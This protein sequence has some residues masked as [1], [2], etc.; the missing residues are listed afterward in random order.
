[1]DSNKYVN[2]KSIIW[3]Y[4]ELWFI[5]KRLISVRMYNEIPPSNDRHISTYHSIR[6]SAIPPDRFLK[7]YSLNS[8][9]LYIFIINP[10]DNI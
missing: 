10:Y 9:W 1:M 8:E 4:C 3:I 6:I 7:S 5:Q 2:R